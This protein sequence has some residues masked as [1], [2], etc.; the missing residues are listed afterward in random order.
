MTNTA[1]Q[2]RQLKEAAKRIFKDIESKRIGSLTPAIAYKDFWKTDIEII[3]YAPLNDY[4]IS[5]FNDEP[6]NLN[7]GIETIVKDDNSSGIRDLIL[8][9]ELFQGTDFPILETCIIGEDSK[10][11]KELLH[12]LNYVDKIKLCL[13]DKDHVTTCILTFDWSPNSYQDDFNQI[14]ESLPDNI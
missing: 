13:A 6:Q 8:K 9:I 14:Y 11:M 10:S 2:K 5:F 1:A 7:I 12:A 3:F 4:A